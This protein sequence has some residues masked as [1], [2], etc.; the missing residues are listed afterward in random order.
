MYWFISEGVKNST[1]IIVEATVVNIIESCHSSSGDV[2]LDGDDCWD[3]TAK[4]GP[5]CSKD[6]SSG[7]SSFWER[8]ITHL[9]WISKEVEEVTDS[10]DDVLELLDLS[11]LVL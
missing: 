1:D 10:G 8:L 6:F 7:V 5:F 3:I 2:F 9:S 4:F 11:V